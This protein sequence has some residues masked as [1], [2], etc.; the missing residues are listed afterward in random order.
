MMRKKVSV[1]VLSICILLSACGT[2]GS[3]FG[4]SRTNTDQREDRYPIYNGIYEVD[5]FFFG[6]DPSGGFLYYYDKTTGFSDFLCADPSC[7]HNSRNCGAYV[8]RTGLAAFYNG[9]RYWATFRTDDGDAAGMLTFWSGDMDGSNRKQIKKIPGESLGQYVPQT[10][11]I[12]DNK[13]YM[14]GIVN[15][16]DDTLIGNRITVLRTSLDGDKSVEKLF[17]EN[18]T[19]NVQARMALVD[20]SVYVAIQTWTNDGVYS[21]KIEKINIDTLE[22][23]TVY[24]E[25]DIPEPAGVPWIT[26]AGAIYIPGLDKMWRIEQEKRV[27]VASF[28]SGIG[29]AE[30][31][32]GIVLQIYISNG[33]RYADI[34]DFSGE[35]IYRGKLFPKDVDGI[36]GDLNT[37]NGYGLTVFGGDREKVIVSIKQFQSRGEAEN[38]EIDNNPTYFLM[39]DLKD[40]MKPTLLWTATK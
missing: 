23:E 21:I 17:E 15:F 34:L 5:N 14:L 33:E 10:S 29:P 4:D 9:K 20:D 16:V 40:N 19:L 25:N 37:V 35:R 1:L 22:Q 12:F 8:D 2:T 27:Q 28:T 18:Y 6:G 32:D 26:G 38:G 7:E 3:N 13:I 39:L 36:T 11:I 30:V 31:Y 24:E